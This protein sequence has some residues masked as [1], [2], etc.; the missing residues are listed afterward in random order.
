MN[1]RPPVTAEKIYPRIKPL[2]FL[3]EVEPLLDQVEQLGGDRERQ[4][5][6]VHPFAGDVELLVTYAVDTSTQ[7]IGLTVEGMEELGLD[8]GAL[9]Q[10][11]VDNM[12]RKVMP[13]LAMQDLAICKALVT[14]NNFE[15]CL[16]LLPGLWAQLS[17]GFA[18]ELL[19]V[20]P[21][22]N[23]IFFMDGGAAIEAEGEE[24][25]ALQRLD[26]MCS[27]AAGIKADAGVH[28]LSDQV[29]AMTED[30]WQVRGTF[31]SHASALEGRRG[32]LH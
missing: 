12:A 14:G 32:P 4:T 31:D 7:F 25:S 8:H 3:D 19:V 27:T 29:F 30:G 15:A 5:P 2:A 10:Q 6:V 22:R 18:G 23:V 20:A 1:T 26:L 11:A 13:N 24:I 9:Y 28:G 21:S 17:E 16:L